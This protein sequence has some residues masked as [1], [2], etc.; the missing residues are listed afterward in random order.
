MPQPVMLKKLKLNG[1]MKPY[2][3]FQNQHPKKYA[4][5]IKGTGMQK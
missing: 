5:F 1:S 3:I 4:L 2:K